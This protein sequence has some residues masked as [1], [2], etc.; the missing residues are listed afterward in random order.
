MLAILKN[1]FKIRLTVSCE[2]STKTLKRKA[3]RKNKNKEGKK[4]K[5]EVEKKKKI[6]LFKC[7]IKKNF[8]CEK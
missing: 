5:K 8:P 7:E 4:R 6:L 2:E 1:P 3:S